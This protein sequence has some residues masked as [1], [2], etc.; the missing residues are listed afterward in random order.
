MLKWFY[1]KLILIGIG[2]W[3]LLK[4]SNNSRLDRLKNDPAFDNRTYQ[5]SYL[6]GDDSET[7][8]DSEKEELDET[9]KFY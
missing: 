6:I 2:L 7:F 4:N 9:L 5:T 8:D 3:F 1:Y